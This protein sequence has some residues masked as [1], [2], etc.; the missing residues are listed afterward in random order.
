[1]EDTGA[2]GHPAGCQTIFHFQVP[3]LRPKPGARPKSEHLA[4]SS[5]NETSGIVRTNFTVADW[6]LQGSMQNVLSR[7]E[8]AAHSVLTLLPLLSVAGRSLLSS[9][10]ARVQGSAWSSSLPV[11]ETSAGTAGE[12][13]LFSEWEPWSVDAWSDPAET[14]GVGHLD[15][16][17]ASFDGL[18]NWDW[19][20]PSP[21]PE[22]LFLP[23]QPGEG[24]RRVSPGRPALPRFVR[25][26]ELRGPHPLVHC[27]YATN[28]RTPLTAI[29][30]RS[31]GKPV[32]HRL[33]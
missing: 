32:S 5:P 8:E 31:S 16:G 23:G 11:G 6:A 15:E 28:G 10:W 12:G 26:P 13:W 22:Q 4:R 33:E 20:A 2:N 9:T 19:T 17:L 21:L 25:G 18:G 1:V 27:A 30:S 24:R 7:H 29:G 14:P 3:L